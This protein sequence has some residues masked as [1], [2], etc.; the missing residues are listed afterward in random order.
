MLP[1]EDVYDYDTR[2]D[3]F[4][5]EGKAEGALVRY[6]ARRLPRGGV[7]LSLRVSPTRL[8]CGLGE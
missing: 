5:M 6:R 4:A 3:S 2:E 1:L 8:S 7:W